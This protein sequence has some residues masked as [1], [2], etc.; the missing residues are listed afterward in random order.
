L[1]VLPT[2]FE[3]WTSWKLMW[4]GFNNA[5]NLNNGQLSKIYELKKMNQQ[6]IIC[7]IVAMIEWLDFH[8]WDFP[9]PY[10]LEFSPSAWKEML[11]NPKYPLK[12]AQKSM[13]KT[14]PVLLVYYNAI[15]SCSYEFKKW[16][17]NLIITNIVGK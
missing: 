17:H 6:Q 5:N 13:N 10:E 7:G 2:N 9:W 16:I 11:T 15:W 12:V 8:L 3:A 14:Y 1:D 4:K